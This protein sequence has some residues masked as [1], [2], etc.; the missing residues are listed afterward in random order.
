M[1]IKT[2]Q[3]SIREAER[4][5]EKAKAVHITEYKYSGLPHSKLDSGANSA[6]CKRASLDLSKVLAKLRQGR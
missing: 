3:E 1:E 5:I 6:A 2:L 4:F